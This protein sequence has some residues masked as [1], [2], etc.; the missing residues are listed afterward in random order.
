[1]IAARLAL[2]DR[3]VWTSP[4]RTCILIDAKASARLD[5]GIFSKQ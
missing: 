1:M 5:G 4:D 3:M 2:H